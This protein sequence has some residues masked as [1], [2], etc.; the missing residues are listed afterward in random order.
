[1]PYEETLS[2]LIGAGPFA[3]IAIAF[4]IGTIVMLGMVITI[5]RMFK[6]FVELQKS[7]NEQTMLTRIA[8]AKMDEKITSAEGAVS[9]VAD[10]AVD[11][12]F[13]LRRLTTILVDRFENSDRRLDDIHTTLTNSLVPIISKIESMSLGALQLEVQ[14]VDAYKNIFVELS[15]IGRNN[16][17]EPNQ[18]NV[19]TTSGD[20]ESE[21]S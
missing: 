19:S 16:N 15:K 9:R 6:V 10:T 8:V 13:E 4:L 7:T 3:S 18:E 12:K 20:L 17:E 2:I 5:S 1:M 21:R 14:I 11:S